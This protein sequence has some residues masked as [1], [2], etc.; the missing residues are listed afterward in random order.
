[1]TLFLL[2]PIDD[3]VSA[4]VDTFVSSDLPLSHAEL[5]LRATSLQETVPATS[6]HQAAGNFILCVAWSFT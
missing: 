2:V 3:I 6:S 1:M 5:I 4:F